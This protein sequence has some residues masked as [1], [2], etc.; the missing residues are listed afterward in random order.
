MPKI[1]IEILTSVV[2]F[3]ALTFSSHAM[4]GKGEIKI[5]S[6]FKEGYQGYLQ[7][8]K[9]E[10]GWTGAF[11]ADNDGAWGWFLA[12]SRVSIKPTLGIN[13]PVARRVP[14][15]AQFSNLNSMGSIPNVSASSSMAV[16]IAKAAAC[17][18]GA[19]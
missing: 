8:M 7:A 2:I 9:E 3:F 17:A 4:F 13:G 5:D 11:A 18:P 16:S 10:K 15:L 14:S 1:F 19:R 12:A 6:S